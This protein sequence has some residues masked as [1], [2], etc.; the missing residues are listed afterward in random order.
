M[1]KAKQSKFPEYDRWVDS[2]RNLAVQSLQYCPDFIERA[3]RHE[4]WWNCQNSRPLFLAKGLSPEEAKRS[5]N[6]EKLANPAEWVANNLL[7]LHNTHFLFDSLPFVHLD[8]GGAMLA[9]M[10]GAKIHY[11]EDH[12]WIT[13]LFTEWGNQPGWQLDQENETTRLFDDLTDVLL[14]ELTGKA[15][16]MSPNLGGGADALMNLMSAEKICQS[17]IDHSDEV[18]TALE[19]INAAWREVYSKLMRAV[20]RNNVG[21]IHWCEVWSNT[22]YLILECE[23]AALV[24]SKHFHQFLIPDILRQ[25][26]SVDRTIFHV[27][28]EESFRHID[29]LLD[30]PQVSAI[31][32]VPGRNNRAIHKIH[33]LQKIQKHGLP[34]QI[35]VM[36][37][38]PEDLLKELDP[39]GLA[40]LILDTLP[41]DQLQP[42]VKTAAAWNGQ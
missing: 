18:H 31:Q 6:F 27:C 3:S 20:I 24:S 23:L 7:D 1:Q 26:E 38:E 4:A 8:L 28:G 21:M 40:F 25:A 39:A 34:L 13:S 2:H 17:L 41:M 37:D 32:Y 19:G 9:G 42:F 29:A 16:L 22:P 36:P 35:S 15:L 30:L 5:R 14:P 10:L 33:E 11:E 12:A